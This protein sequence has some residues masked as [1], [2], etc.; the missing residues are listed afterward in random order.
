MKKKLVSL[1]FIVAIVA[2]PAFLTS[3]GDDEMETIVPPKPE[4]DEP[5]EDKFENLYGYWINSDYSGAMEIL[6]YSSD[7]C[8]IIYFVYTSKGLKN[9][10]SYYNGGSG[11]FGA[12]TQDGK[13]VAVEVLSS[14][15]NKLVLKDASGQG[16]HLSSYVFS[17]VNESKF[18]EYLEG[19]NSGNGDD[20]N[21]QEDDAKKL[22]GTWIGYDGTPGLD[23]T[24]KYTITFYSSG[25][26]TEV[27]SYSGG[28]ESTSGT[29]KYSNGKITEWE[30]EDGSALA[31]TLGD[32]SD[33]PWIVTFITSTEI[34]I[35]DKYYSITFNKQ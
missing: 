22:I 14:S 26:A 19:K 31:N 28:S 16:N 12:L 33:S 11:F 8:E 18:Y 17:R 27:C 13:N 35:G 10:E 23:W 29:Y 9:H 7:R 30:M 21:E 2:M 15:L 24:D 32:P 6:E 3:C 1:L 4:P 34:A 25:K 20:N 5:K